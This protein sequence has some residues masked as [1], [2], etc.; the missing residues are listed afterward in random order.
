[1]GALALDW[2][3]LLVLAVASYRITRFV[4]HDS[5]MGTG[6]TESGRFASGVAE[7]IDHFA[8]TQDEVDAL[9]KITK[10]GGDNRSFLRGKIGDLLTCT[11]CLGFWI[12]VGVYFAYLSATVGQAGIEATPWAVHGITVFAIAGVQSYINSRP[13]A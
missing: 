1:M 12:S 11:F 3:E 10:Q 4:V 5:L 8:Y 7:R 6:I 2:L 9:G 13:L